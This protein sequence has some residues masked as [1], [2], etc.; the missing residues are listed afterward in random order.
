MSMLSVSSS[1]D[2]GGPGSSGRPLGGGGVSNSI[3]EVLRDGRR[4]V[5]SS[6]E[7]AA[8][9]GVAAGGDEASESGSS[10][11]VAAW[12]GENGRSFSGGG[13]S[14]GRAIGVGASCILSSLPE[15]CYMKN[16]SMVNTEEITNVIEI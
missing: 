1:E 3:L 9:M 7:G 4:G 15:K 12:T 11:A 2:E 14:I 13:I 16:S 8:S 5:E 10:A 6:K